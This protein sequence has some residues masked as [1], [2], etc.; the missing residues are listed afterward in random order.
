MIVFTPSKHPEPSDMLSF[1]LKNIIN[2]QL[3]VLNKQSIEK[4]ALR[5]SI[6]KI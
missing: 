5:L 2:E 3:W 1:I 4:S 6:E